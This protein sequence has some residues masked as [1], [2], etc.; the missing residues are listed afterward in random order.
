M[1]NSGGD[2]IGGSCGGGL[3]VLCVVI[4]IVYKCLKDNHHSSIQP[5]TDHVPQPNAVK[6]QNRAPSCPSSRNSPPPT[7]NEVF[8]MVECADLPCA[9]MSAPPANSKKPAT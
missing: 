5:M 7:Y 3:F 2:L 4:F 6:N 8:E 1:T 9:C